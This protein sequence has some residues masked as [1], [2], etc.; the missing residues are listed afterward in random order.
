MKRI[1][2]LLVTLWML[3]S[4]ATA[5]QLEVKSM[6]FISNDLSAEHH[7]RKDINGTPCALVKVVT[8]GENARFEGNVLGNVTYKSG[9]YWVYLSTGTTQLRIS[10]PGFLPLHVSFAKHGVNKVMSGKTYQLL[11]EASKDMQELTIYGTPTD[12]IVLIDSKPYTMQNGSVS[13]KLPVGE[14][15]Y[16]VTAD[17]Y[18][19]VNGSVV[20]NVGTP[21]NIRFDLIQSSIHQLTPEQMFTQSI[22]YLNGTNGKKRDIEKGFNL[23]QLAAEKGQP[24]AQLQMGLILSK[25]NNE[26][27]ARYWYQKSANQGHANA[28]FILGLSFANE[29]DY[30]QAVPW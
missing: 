25:A 11:I 21:A 9:E 18:E 10:I 20:L 26:E 15:S 7:E 16:L 5:Q 29:K 12:A 19:P 27:Q 8:K 17:G 28:Q 24:D 14:H 2:C 1:V 6:S 22:D 30:K 4:Y 13:T 3:L 23:L